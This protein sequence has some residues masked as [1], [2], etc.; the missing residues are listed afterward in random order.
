MNVLK[1]SLYSTLFTLFLIAAVNVQAQTTDDGYRAWLRYV[2]VD[3]A[4]LLKDYQDMMKAV[5]LRGES[6]TVRAVQNELQ[7]AIPGLLET[8]IPFHND[9]QVDGTLLI[10]TPE[11][12]EEI[13]SLNLQNELLSLGRE[14]YLILNKRL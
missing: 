1:S 7:Q 8:E 5:V 10:G 4:G 3:D 12:S 9:I 6:E 14:G 11:S 2:K 13:A